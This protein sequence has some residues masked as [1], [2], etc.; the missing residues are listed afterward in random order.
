MIRIMKA[1]RLL[2]ILTI[3]LNRKKVSAPRLAKELEVSLRTIYRDVEA[4]AESGIPVYATQGRDGGFELMEGF[5]MDSQVLETG[6]VSRILTGLKGLQAVYPDPG[7][8]GLIEK[9]SLMLSASAG[10]GIKTPENHVF[11]ELSPCNRE[12]EILERIETAIARKGVLS[13]EYCDTR[14]EQTSRLVEPQALVFIWQ[15]W[16]A[17]G[18][19]GLRQDFRLFKLSRILSAED[20]P[21]PRTGEAANLAE[22]PWNR[23]WNTVA[24]E[25]IVFRAEQRTR[26]KLGEFFDPSAIEELDDGWVEVRTIF[27]V[28]EWIMSY[29]MGLPGA[30]RVLEPESLRLQILERART[31]SANNDRG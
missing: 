13:V 14:G 8:V 27:P 24:P 17:Y 1:E 25:E 2:A 29:I 6:E 21:L 3:L 22:H 9:F 28:D 20:V 18:W 12:R 5:A 31:I 30:V 16:Y 23:H 19:C 26:A 15:S 10:K 4:L 11:I 7:M